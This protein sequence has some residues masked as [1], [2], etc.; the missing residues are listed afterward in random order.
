MARYDHLPIYKQALELLVYIEQI[1]KGFS[2]YNKYTI[3]TRLRETC[4][5]VTVLIVKANNQPTSERRELLVTLRDKIEE[6]NIGL[7]V[8][9]ELKVFAKYNSYRHAAKLAVDLSRQSEGWLKSVSSS[10]SPES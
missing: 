6:V 8:A 9:K 2:R 7:S 4:W 1:V 5:D 3:G 10:P